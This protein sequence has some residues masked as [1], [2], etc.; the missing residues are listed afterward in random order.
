M[1]KKFSYD[2]FDEYNNRGIQVAVSFLRQLGY[3][4]IN[5]DE[6]YK[7]HDFVVE[8]DGQ[9]YKIECEV[10]QKWITTAFPYRYMSIPYRKKD[11]KADYYIRSNNQGTALY[12]LP[13]KDILSAEVINKD[14]IYSTNEPFF[15]LSVK[16]LKLY[17]FEDGDWFEDE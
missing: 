16:N 15:N 17:Y 2:L 8:K 12:F 3:K 1:N 10:T 11:S 4:P 14:T 6:A 9:T 13:M 7:S 5:F